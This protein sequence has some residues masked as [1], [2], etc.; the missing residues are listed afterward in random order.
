MFYV[1]LVDIDFLTTYGNGK[2]LYDNNEFWYK[3]ARYEKIK[4]KVHKM[5]TAI[6]QSEDQFITTMK[7]EDQSKFLFES[8]HSSF[9]AAFELSSPPQL[10]GY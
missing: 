9:N 6:S 3:N 2:E 10:M 5:F 4:P 7:G 8:L 1:C